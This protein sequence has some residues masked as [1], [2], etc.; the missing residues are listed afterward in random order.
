MY[1]FKGFSA[2][3]VAPCN[4]VCGPEH[5]VG[6]TTPIFSHTFSLIARLNLKR[7]Y[8]R[9]GVRDVMVRVAVDAGKYI[10]NRYW[11]MGVSTTSEVRTI[12]MM[13]LFAK[14]KKKSERGKR[15][16]A[17]VSCGLLEPHRVLLVSGNCG[18]GRGVVPSLAGPGGGFSSVDTTSLE[19]SVLECDVVSV[20]T[21]GLRRQCFLLGE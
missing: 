6:H 19:C 10:L 8:P 3:P 16:F 7:C 17:V 13:I 11:A 4:L 18:R 20:S 1:A 21:P 15:G 14:K 9:T 2:S 5:F 12:T